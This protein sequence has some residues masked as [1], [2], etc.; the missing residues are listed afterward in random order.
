MLLSTIILS[1]LAAPVSPIPAPSPASCWKSKYE[2][3]CCTWS[4][5]P[6]DCGCACLLTWVIVTD[7]PVWKKYNIYD[8]G[9][10]LTDIPGHNEHC[11][12]MEVICD[13]TGGGCC[14]LSGIWSTAT[15]SSYPNP[16][17]EQ[18]CP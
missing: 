12:V 13:H 10:D 4:F 1:T 11:R 2:G 8:D 7:G 9:W 6:P 16:E 3:T 18:T 5:Q 15:C 14:V 17:I